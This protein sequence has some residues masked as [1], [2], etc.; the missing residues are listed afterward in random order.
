MDSSEFDDVKGDEE[1]LTGR[2]LREGI[3][4]DTHILALMYGGELAYWAHC[5]E[6]EPSGPSCLPYSARLASQPYREAA[7]DLLGRYARIVLKILRGEGWDCKRAMAL[8]SEL[9]RN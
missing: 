2:L 7:L 9:K 3:F 8:M 4:S 1:N 6:L 5:L